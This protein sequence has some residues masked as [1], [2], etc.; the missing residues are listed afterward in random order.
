MNLGL[1]LVIVAG[2]S[3]PSVLLLAL[4]RRR[5]DGPLLLEP[6]RGTPM[7]T[8]VGTAFAVLLASGARAAFQT[9]NGGKRGAQ[10]EAVAVLEMARTAALFPSAQRDELRAD[11]VCYGRA[12]V[13]QERPGMGK[14]R[15][16]P[17]G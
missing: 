11:L 6:T 16:K 14:G 13:R 5:V 8:I 2:A 3:R 12:R 15:A 10:S 17:R 9:Y 1:G 7:M 4:V